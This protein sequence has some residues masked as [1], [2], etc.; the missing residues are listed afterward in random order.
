MKIE[1]AK[2]ASRNIVFGLILKIFQILVP[3]LLRTTMIY[4][5]GMK[6]VGLNSLF[7]SVL[8]VLNLAELG[9]GNAMVFSMYKPI[10]ED[11]NEKICALMQLYKVYYRVIGGIIAVVGII[12]TPFIPY[13]VKG[14]VPTGINIYVLY[15][16]NLGATVLSYWLF[17]YKNS[18]LQAH[19]RNDV[20]SKVMLVTSMIQY[21]IQILVLWLLRNYYVYVIVSLFTQALTNIVI[22]YFANKLYPQFRPYGRIPKEDVSVINKRIRDLF[23]AKLGSVILTSVDTIVISAFLGLTVL[24]IYQNYY[25][26]LSSVIGVI[27]VVFSSVIAGIGNSLI[28]ESVEKNYNDLNKFTFLIN[29]ILCIGCCCFA[30]L[31]QPFMTIWVGNEY[32]LSYSYIV[33]FVI[34]FYLCELA[35][36]WA[37]IKDAAGLWHNDR[38]RPLI[39]ATANLIMNIILVQFIGLYG[40]VLSTIISYLFISMPWLVHNIFVLI[41]K[42]SPK[43]YIFKLA[44]YIGTTAFSV[45]ACVFLTNQLKLSPL[46]L[47]ALNTV[48]CILLSNGI[49]YIVFRKTKEFKESKE[50]VLNMLKR[51]KYS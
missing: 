10:A 20:A 48:I 30:C 1:R 36:V 46:F 15:L 9:V 32:M 13:L 38:F 5:M 28:N 33:C 2:N 26:I 24:A 8:Q 29:W 50:L 6:Y 23:T 39:G 41:Y 14:D 3:F 18:I 19:Q 45:V 22:A 21:G 34:Y 7:A 17:A 11:D 40:I 27:G 16:L 43:N 25:Y 42:R 49:Q 4:F 31:Y 51:G 44:T 35:L 47:F 12:L 37:T